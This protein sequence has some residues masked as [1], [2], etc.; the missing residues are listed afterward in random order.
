MSLPPLSAPVV[1]WALLAT[2]IHLVLGY[3]AVDYLTPYPPRYG[4][5]GGLIPDLDVALKLVETTFPFVHRGITHTPAFLAVLILGMWMLGVSEATL[6]G[7]GIGGMLHLLVDTASGWG[8]MWF[9]PARTTRVLLPLSLN[10][11]RTLLVLVAVSLAVI[12]LLEPKRRFT[13]ID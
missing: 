8:V 3:L 9:W 10:A 7:V 11:R 2:A 4:L 1:S 5:V 6:H 13:R 12:L